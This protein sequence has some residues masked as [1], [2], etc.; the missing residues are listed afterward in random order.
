[1]TTK[2][3]IKR[4][5]IGKITSSLIGM[6][7]VASFGVPFLH[8]LLISVIISVLTFIKDVYLQKWFL[9]QEEKR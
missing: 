4:V 1:M 2:R 7:V 9:T 8:N 3:A 5:L 6:V